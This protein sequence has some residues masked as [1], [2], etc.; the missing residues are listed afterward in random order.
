[1][2][3]PFVPTPRCDSIRLDANGPSVCVC[4]YF[5]V[6][7]TRG[8]GT[9]PHYLWCCGMDS[10]QIAARRHRAD[11]E[12]SFNCEFCDFNVD[13]WNVCVIWRIYCSINVQL[14]IL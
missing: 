10:M 2:N 14:A 12:P 4:V 9:M 1:M 7:H 13:N 5:Y 8:Y 6:A 11:V 3:I